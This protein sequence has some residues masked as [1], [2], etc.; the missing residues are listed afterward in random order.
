MVRDDCDFDTG[1]ALTARNANIRTEKVACIIKIT[2]F[3]ENT[4]DF[5][6]AFETTK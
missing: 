3:D 1:A 6:Q 4:A 2:N 5:Y